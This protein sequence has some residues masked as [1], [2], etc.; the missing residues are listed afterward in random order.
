M[1]VVPPDC[2]NGRFWR[3]LDETEQAAL[4]EVGKPRGYQRGATMIHATDTA[5]WAAVLLSGRVRV[6][7]GEHLAGARSAGDIIGEQRILEKQP[8]HVTVRAETPVRALVI[9]GADLD[10][11][12]DRQPGVL[13]ALCAVLSERLRECDE[14]LAGLSGDA[15]TKLVRFLA[16][17]ADGDGPFSVHIGSQ[18]RLG[19]ALGVS[20]D[21]VIRALRQLRKDNVV[22]TRRGLVTVRDTRAL[23]GYPR[24]NSGASA[25]NAAERNK[26]F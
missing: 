7:N 23:R 6:L 12:L 19:E 14:R 20:R 8:R 22:T 21:S 18:E 10:R 16:L 24:N 26:Y 5:R 25:A 15:F 2:W 17:S 4:L 1:T 13:R 11:V 9:D 3:R